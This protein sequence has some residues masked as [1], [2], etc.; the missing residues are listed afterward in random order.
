M[1]QEIIR[2]IEQVGHIS[3]VNGTKLKVKV[4]PGYLTEEDKQTLRERKREIIYHLKDRARPYLDEQGVL[5]IP[6]DSDPR[7]HWWA[8]GQHVLETL[9]E[10][11]APPKVLVRYRP[12]EEAHYPD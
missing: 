11:N 7:Y 2:K 3:V 6:F 10:L 5:V 1:P 8:G 9:R 4:P 12:D